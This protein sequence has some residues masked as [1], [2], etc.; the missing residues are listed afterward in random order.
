MARAGILRGGR[1]LVYPLVGGGRPK[2][3][4]VG[5]AAPPEPD[6]PAVPSSASELPALGTV[7]LVLA[8][9][10]HSFRRL[11]GFLGLPLALIIIFRAYHAG[12]DGPY[13]SVRS[14]D[15]KLIE[16]H[17]DHQVALYHL[18]TDIGEKNN[19][20]LIEPERFEQ[21]REEMEA[22]FNNLFSE[23][24]SAEGAKVPPDISR[25]MKALG[26]IQ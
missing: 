11:G 24:T 25:L 18:S 5:W 9:T 2:Y 8:G 13:S 6:R 1:A 3:L 12:G 23:I 21:E 16:F 22:F 26:Y 4:A 10:I 19:L 14:E 15:W 17:E 20:A 7:L